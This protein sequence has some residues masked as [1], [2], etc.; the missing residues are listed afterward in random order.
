MNTL[1]TITGP[2]CS[3][4]ST[5]L[6]LLCSKYNFSQILSTMTRRP[7]PGETEGDDG[8]FVSREE[9]ERLMSVGEMSQTVTFSGE[10]YG[11]TWREIDRILAQGKVPC[12]I[13]EPSGVG[14]YGSISDSLGLRRISVYV[15]SPL[16]QLVDRYAHRLEG[17]IL[18][19]KELLYHADR[20]SSIK[21]EH[22]EWPDYAF[23]D[24]YFENCGTV[25]CLEQIAQDINQ[26]LTAEE[27]DGKSRAS[28]ES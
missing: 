11:S 12:V 20:I 10:Y 21:R 27:H 22:S 9:F 2:S 13:V 26:L 3:G 24:R 16:E 15:E 1:L 14:Q 18:S 17:R 7:R 23:F 5:L 28:E 25:E 19:A 6:K 8:Y 4:K